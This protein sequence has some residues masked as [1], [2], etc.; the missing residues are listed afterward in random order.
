M[1]IDRTLIGLALALAAL[2]AHPAPAAPAPAAAATAAAAQRRIF[3]SEGQGDFGGVRLRYAAAVEEVLLPGASIFVTS[4]VRSDIR[5]SGSRPVIFAFNGGPGS[6]SLWLHLGVMGPRRVDFDDPTRPRTVAPF[7]TVANPD[8]PLDVADIVLIDPPGTGYSRILPGGKPEQYYGVEQDAKA[9]VQVVEQWLRRHGRV[10]SPK[11]L[12]SESYGTVRAAVMAR[13]MAGGPTQTGTM[14]GLTLNGVVLL[15]QAMEMARGEGE[16]RGYVA[17]LPSLAATA[18]HFGKVAAGCTPEGQVAAARRFI[19]SDYLS[20]LHAGSRLPAER[21][22]AVAREMAA[23]IGL[24]EKDILAADLR[25]SGTAFAR[26]L[27][28][29]QGQRL[30]LYDARFTLPLQGAG[31]DPVGDDPAMGQYVPGF[32][33][34][35]NDYARRTL[36]VDLDIPYEPIAFRDVNGRWDFG[37]GPGVPVGKNYAL[38]LAAAMNRNPAMRLMVGTGYYDLVTPLG[39]ADYVIAHAGIP[40]ARTSFHGYPSGHGPYLGVEARTALVHDLRAFVSPAK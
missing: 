12:V 3:R 11:Y 14:D 1:G 36:K 19:E 35:W 13:L 39:S 29:D 34:A 20:A 15:G 27:L 37:F 8:S 9:M 28:A 17:I 31:G 33:G 4:Y 25:I 22:T 23:L 40:L 24:S 7:A 26:L 10:N 6:A 38:D 30:G 32:V 18:C 21:K 16:D 5:D 2:P